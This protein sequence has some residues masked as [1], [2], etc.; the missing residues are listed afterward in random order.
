[1]ESIH[2][3]GSFSRLVSY[4]EWDFSSWCKLVFSELSS[5]KSTLQIKRFSISNSI[6]LMFLL[7]L[8]DV[9]SLI[10]ASIRATRHIFPYMNLA[11]PESLMK[12]L[13]CERDMS[14]ST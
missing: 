4:L 14:S 6:S 7:Y 5:P 8:T 13:R 1:M 10:V 9:A 2:G 12:S 3:V 11:L